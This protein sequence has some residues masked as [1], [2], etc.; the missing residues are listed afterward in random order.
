VS[1]HVSRLRYQKKGFRAKL[2]NGWFV[3]DD[4]AGRP[5][6]G[7]FDVKSDARME[8]DRLKGAR[9]MN[10]EE[11]TKTSETTRTQSDQSDSESAKNTNDGSSPTDGREE[12]VIKRT[13]R[14]EEKSSTSE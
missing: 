12:E 6:A 3:I 14:T 10:T 5:V 11:K 9:V 4:V 1:L 8:R 13:Q 2:S 7:P